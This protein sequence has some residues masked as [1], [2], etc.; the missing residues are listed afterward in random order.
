MVGQGG[1]NGGRMGGKLKNHFTITSPSHPDLTVFYPKKRGKTVPKRHRTN[2]NP[3][4]FPPFLS[5]FCHNKSTIWPGSLAQNSKLVYNR[6][7]ADSTLV[8]TMTTM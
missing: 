5:E 8:Y 1:E 6:Y 4:I 2:Q 3:A 7:Y